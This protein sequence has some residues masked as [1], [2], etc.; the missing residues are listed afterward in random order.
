MFDALKWLAD[1]GHQEALQKIVDIALPSRSRGPNY[2]DLT[3]ARYSTPTMN[4]GLLTSSSND[5]AGPPHTS[6]YQMVRPTNVASSNDYGDP[7]PR[8]A[9]ELSNVASSGPSV[10]PPPR[11]RTS[12][13]T[14]SSPSSVVP[15]PVSV[16]DANDIEDQFNNIFN[17]NF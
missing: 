12:N 10:G 3:P 8:Y 13:V 7:P 4:A 6:T 5:S 15:P 2:L 1:R 11:F 16:T 9:W 14:S 17:T